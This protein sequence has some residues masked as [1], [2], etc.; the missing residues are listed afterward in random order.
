MNGWRSLIN[1]IDLVG[2]LVV[3][4]GEFSLVNLC[5]EFSFWDFFYG[6]IDFLRGDFYLACP[7]L[8]YSNVLISFVANSNCILAESICFAL[9]CSLLLAGS[10]VFLDCSKL[11]S[12]KI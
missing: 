3:F 12:V 7:P 11:K 9:S 2:D 1:R 4:V 10:C 8:F 5:G 6:E